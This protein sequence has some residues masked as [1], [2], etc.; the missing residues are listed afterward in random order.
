MLTLPLLW[1]L[2]VGLGVLVTGAWAGR[3]PLSAEDGVVRY[4]SA[5]RTAAG[6]T[7]SQGLS[8]VAGTQGV[9]AVTL[10]C[11]VALLVLPR[12]PGRAAAYF[13]AGAV[14]A[15]SAVFV[16]VTLCVERLRP[17][18][19]HLE[20]AP[21][22]SSFPSGHSGAALA[23]YGGL[24]VLAGRRR[25]W[26]LPAVALLLCLP[27]AVAASRLYAGMH[28][29]SDVVGG[30]L[31]GACTLFVLARALPPSGGPHGGPP[32]S[33]PRDVAGGRRAVVV[34][35][36]HACSDELAEAVRAVLDRHGYTDQRWTLTTAERPNG[37]LE[38][39]AA[40]F[41][42]ALV[43]ACGGDGTVRA[44]AEPLLGTDT[45]LA[46]VPCGTGNLLARNLRLPL[47][48]AAAL[49]RA[50]VG[51]TTRIDVGRV[52]G[53]GL[54][55]TCFTVMAGAGFDAAMVRDASARLKARLGWSAY[56][57]S[58]AG[59]LTD[60]RMHLAMRLDGGPELRRRARMV[61]IGNVGVL[62]GGLPL[63]PAARPDSGRLDLVLLNPRGLTGWAAAA[64]HLAVRM[65]P[66]RAGRRGGDTATGSPVARGALE[67]FQARRIDIG[68]ATPQ[69]REL[70]GDVV[71]DGTR[72]TI[73]VQP[74]ALPVR[75]PAPTPAPATAHEPRHDD[76]AVT[77][78]G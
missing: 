46:I 13:L 57:V 71:A 10:L 30:L 29:P 65:L 75:L 16:L 42:T 26:R 74:G 64:G 33:R 19:P 67:Y 8:L 22:T 38:A 56:V 25:R 17:D 5:H 55:A 43:V 77:S 39:P 11:V 63:L 18:V 7:V 1:A 3:W 47:D 6:D 73:E 62:Q 52:H 28:H 68:F 14:A 54:P 49:E 40:R 70:D 4:L 69:A 61:L 35:H 34:R 66:R 20:Q 27:A 60:P 32:G 9:I 58:G 44:C 53:D 2:L 50:L 31:N 41:G 48:P 36:P 45:A 23:L 15:Q 24:A 76:R 21:P 59:H 78:G 51:R 12:T 72:L 37:E